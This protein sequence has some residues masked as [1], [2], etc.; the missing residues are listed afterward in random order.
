MNPSIVPLTLNIPFE[1]SKTPPLN[2]LNTRFIST[3][4]ISLWFSTTSQWEMLMGYRLNCS[5]Q[6]ERFPFQSSRQ[7]M[8]EILAPSKVHHIQL[9]VVVHELH[10]AHVYDAMLLLNNVLKLMYIIE[11]EGQAEVDVPKVRDSQDKSAEV[12]QEK[13]IQAMSYPDTSG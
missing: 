7:P 12:E 1:S 3:L 10:T 9:H 13:Q 11:I 6:S 2:D 5:D 8:R 4:P